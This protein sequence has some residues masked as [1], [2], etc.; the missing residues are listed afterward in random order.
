MA[1]NSLV[2]RGKF[3]FNSIILICIIALLLFAT[4]VQA[5]AQGIFTEWDSTKTKTSQPN[6]F[7]FVKSV[8]NGQPGVLR[9]V[10]IPHILALPIVQQ[11]VRHPEFV[12]ENYGE[13]TQVNMATQAGN[14]G[15]LAHNNLSGETFSNLL[16]G[17]EVRLIYGDGKIESFIVSQVLRYQA[18]EPYNANSEFRDLETDILITAEELFRK[19]YLGN[20]HV[21][22]QTCIEVNGDGSWGRLF[23]IA[24][25][26]TPVSYMR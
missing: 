13:V 15:L 18:L 1:P 8:K 9:G 26:K 22:F 25:P 12:S 14:I 5:L 10:Y 11:P 20:R 2:I 4:P 6:Y 24:Q 3:I 7:S 21:T 23:V 17:Q 16:P 19:M